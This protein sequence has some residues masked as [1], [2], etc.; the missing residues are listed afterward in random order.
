MSI[1]SRIRGAE[2][3]YEWR[4]AAWQVHSNYTVQ[5][6]QNLTTSQQLLR[7]SHYNFTFGTQFE[8]ENESG[9]R[10]CCWVA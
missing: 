4:G 2:L 9:H 1:S 5:D 8:I 3:E 10:D 7:R 6:P